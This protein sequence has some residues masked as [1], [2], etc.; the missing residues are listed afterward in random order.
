VEHFGE[1][2]PAW[3][4][5]SEWLG[6]GGEGFSVTVLSELGRLSRTSEESFVKALGWLWSEKPQP[7]KVAAERIRSLDPL[8]G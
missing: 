2:E 4:E 5:L 1:R 8:L 6:P 7:A 3:R